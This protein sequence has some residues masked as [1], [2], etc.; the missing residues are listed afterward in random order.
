M[1]MAGL[2]VWSRFVALG[3]SLW[4]DAAYSLVTY[5]QPGPAAAFHHYVPNDHMLFEQLA[6]VVRALGAH[7]TSAFRLVSVV[8]SLGSILV[9]AL[10]LWRGQE[11]V[12]MLAFLLLAV[13]SP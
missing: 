13:T 12:A 5:V 10:W 2:A 6:W 3:R 9:V 7:C 8:P 1:A 4:L 11:R